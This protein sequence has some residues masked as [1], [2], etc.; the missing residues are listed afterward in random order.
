ML[1]NTAVERWRML[2]QGRPNAS[3][4]FDDPTRILVVDDDPLLCETARVYLSRLGAEVETAPD[5]HTALDLMRRR[6]FDV[7]LIDILMPGLDGF[8]LLERVRA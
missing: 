6:E 2:T 1:A 7:A 3:F 8:G 4:V 5:G